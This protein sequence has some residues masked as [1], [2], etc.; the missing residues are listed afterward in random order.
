M[1]MI[2]LTTL[3][4]SI[5]S[6][7]L[8]LM[9]FVLVKEDEFINRCCGEV[10]YFGWGVNGEIQLPVGRLKIGNKMAVMCSNDIIDR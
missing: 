1:K 8:G 6:F 7:V 10:G 2:V 9:P 4:I 5:D 3:P